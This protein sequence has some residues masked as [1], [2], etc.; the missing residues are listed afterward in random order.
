MNSVSEGLLAIT[1]TGDLTESLI[2][3][4]PS[5][6]PSNTSLPV[7]QSAAPLLDR[8]ENYIEFVIAQ[9]IDL[10]YIPIVTTLGIIGNVT[11]TLVLLL[12]S[13][14]ESTTCLYLSTIEILDTFV[15]MLCIVFFINVYTDE[16]V[17]NDG[18]C[19]FIYFL[20]LFVIH[21][22]VLVLLA[23]TVERYIVVTFP[24]HAQR[25]AGWRQAVVVIS[26]AGVVSF[27]I[28]L[29]SIFTRSMVTNPVTG[30]FY[31]AIL[32]WFGHCDC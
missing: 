9:K 32:C 13:F 11:S 4:S 10:I 3:T 26:M 23:M 20:F 24:L 12:S 18:S 19:P 30:Q 8:P 15:L 21:F 6:T 25:F 16:H 17:V 7:I 31:N 29:H 28:N 2:T 1:D 27:G 5:F 22:D 14:R